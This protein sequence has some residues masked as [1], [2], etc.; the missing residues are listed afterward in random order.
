M[1]KRS[2]KLQILWKKYSKFRNILKGKLKLT[3]ITVDYNQLG[4]CVCA[5][6]SSSTA[7]HVFQPSQVKIVFEL[8]E[9]GSYNGNT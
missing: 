6:I 3:S 5:A 8:I 9:L 4:R 7:R 2:V 1:K